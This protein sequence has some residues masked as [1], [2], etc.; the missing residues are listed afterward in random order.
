MRVKGFNGF[1]IEIV[2]L[3]NLIIV[4]YNIIGEIDFVVD[5]SNWK[6]VFLLGEV[7]FFV[8]IIN[9]IED[10]WFGKL[11]RLFIYCSFFIGDLVDRF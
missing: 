1:V 5:V 2:Y 3:D 11:K 6:V 7:K 8:E 4:D 10:F 9:K